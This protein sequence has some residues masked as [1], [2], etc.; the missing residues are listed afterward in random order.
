M[1]NIITLDFGQAVFLTSDAG[2]SDVL[3]I[4]AEKLSP[5]SITLY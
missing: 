1:Y 2:S 5:D 3:E 4:L